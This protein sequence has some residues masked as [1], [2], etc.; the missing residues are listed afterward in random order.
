MALSVAACGAA[1]VDPP[2]DVCKVPQSGSLGTVVLEHGSEDHAP[3][4]EGETFTVE[5]GLQGLYMFVLSAR[6]TGM[7]IADGDVAAVW[8]TAY[9]P[10]NEQI[11]L[12]TGCRSRGFAASEEGSFQMT[13]AYFVP[14]TPDH[15]DALAGNVTL[16]T[17]V[18]DV[19]GNEAT[20]R[21]SVVAATP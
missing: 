6:V 8:F 1:P 9:G 10:A 12:E 7:D 11:S 20:S 14:I 17:I 15:Y 13:D 5:L 4:V 3:V 18:R 21:V 2:F 19:S 16:E